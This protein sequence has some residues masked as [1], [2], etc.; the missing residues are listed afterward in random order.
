VSVLD[1]AVYRWWWGA[2][3]LPARAEHALHQALWGAWGFRRHRS[4]RLRTP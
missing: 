2:R 1:R 4:R 3:P